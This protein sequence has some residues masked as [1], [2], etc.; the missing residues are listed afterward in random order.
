MIEV[1]IKRHK[2]SIVVFFFKFHYIKSPFFGKKREAYGLCQV[3]YL[4]K[5]IHFWLYK[6][7]VENVLKGPFR[8][9]CDWSFLQTLFRVHTNKKDIFTLTILHVSPTLYCTSRGPLTVYTLHRSATNLLPIKH[10]WPPF[11]TSTYISRFRIYFFRLLLARWR[12]V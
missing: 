2:M 3:I 9:L 7:F 4:L 8:P 6:I 5:K 11:C 12:E 10:S 1:G